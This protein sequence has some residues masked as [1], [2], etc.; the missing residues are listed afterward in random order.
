MS[1]YNQTSASGVGL[2]FL[3]NVQ[4]LQY[5]SLDSFLLQAHRDK[6]AMVLDSWVI[7][8][9]R[10]LPLIR[11]NV[12]ARTWK[13]NRKLVIHRRHWFRL[14]KRVMNVVATIG[15]MSGADFQNQLHSRYA[16]HDPLRI[17]AGRAA[18]IYG[19]FEM[20]LVFRT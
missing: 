16:G 8:A 2:I 15:H 1:T 12:F 14:S 18:L 3:P 17:A 4:A 19:G 5:F 20:S 9:K 13:I 6:L 11:I 10:V 7:F